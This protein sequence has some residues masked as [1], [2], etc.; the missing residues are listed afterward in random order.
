MSKSVFPGGGGDGDGEGWSV[1]YDLD[2]SL[3]SNSGVFQELS[4]WS[5]AENRDAG[6]HCLDDGIQLQ[7]SIIFIWHALPTTCWL[8]EERDGEERQGVCEGWILRN[9]ITV[10]GVVTAKGVLT[11][12]HIETLSN[13]VASVGILRSDQRG[14]PRSVLG[15]WSCRH[16]DYHGYSAM[17][18]DHTVWAHAKTNDALILFPRVWSG[19]VWARCLISILNLPTK[20]SRFSSPR[21]F[22]AHM[23]GNNVRMLLGR[24]LKGLVSRKSSDRQSEV[25]S[26]TSLLNGRTWCDVISSLTH[27]LLTHISIG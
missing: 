8:L 9:L 7:L 4:Q 18:E 13:S 1:W 19:H 27:T 20:S 5:L 25:G 15:P 26:H 22:T 17:S 21:N 23:L 11:D 14:G 12:W 2:Y 3:L 6:L 10:R 16:L 24:L